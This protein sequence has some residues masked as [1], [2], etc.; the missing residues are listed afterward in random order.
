MSFATRAC[1]CI[2]QWLNTT[3]GAIFIINP[4]SPLLLP[5]VAAA[6]SVQ[7]ATQWVQARS[8][9]SK[10]LLIISNIFSPVD[11]PSNL[12]QHKKSSDM[13]A[14]RTYLT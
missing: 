5:V 13:S 1:L 6:P 2:M 12:L 11:L 10:Y 7:T 8:F 14:S 3:R 4:L 9:S